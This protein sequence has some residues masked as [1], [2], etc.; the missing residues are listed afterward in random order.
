MSGES[1]GGEVEPGT[2]GIGNGSIDKRDT[3]MIEGSIIQRTAPFH[4]AEAAQGYIGEITVERKK[5]FR[6]FGQGAAGLETNTAA[7]EI[8]SNCGII[9]KPIQVLFSRGFDKA[10]KE[11]PRHPRMPTAVHGLV[12]NSP[13]S[14][15]KR[16]PHVLRAGGAIPPFTIDSNMFRYRQIQTLLA[17]QATS[18]LLRPMGTNLLEKTT[19]CLGHKKNYAVTL[20]K[21][22]KFYVLRQVANTSPTSQPVT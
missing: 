21:C 14:R 16:L 9:D 5:N 19:L 22:N 15:T 7:A 11:T 20:S 10:K 18:I 3:C 2:D 12:D 4:L 8:Y 13:G 1:V 6:P 17:E